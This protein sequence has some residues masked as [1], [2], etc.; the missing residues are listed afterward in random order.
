MVGPE[1]VPPGRKE[2]SLNL[3]RTRQ[4]A[5]NHRVAEQGFARIGQRGARKR[6]AAQVAFGLAEHADQQRRRAQAQHQQQQQQGRA[7]LACQRRRLHLAQGARRPWRLPLVHLQRLPR[8]GRTAWRRW[9]GW[10]V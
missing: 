9:P 10:L 7:A 1:I 2:R 3:R 5:V 4:P 6:L 8:Q